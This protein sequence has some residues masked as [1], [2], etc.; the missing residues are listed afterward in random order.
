MYGGAKTLPRYVKQLWS[1]TMEFKK[2][3]AITNHYRVREIEKIITAN[4][5]YLPITICFQITEKLHGA[6]FSILVD[7]NTYTMAKRTSELTEDENFYGYQEVMTGY[8]GLINRLVDISK[9]LDKPVQLYGELFGGNI[10]KGVWYG[11]DKKFRWYA[12][13]LD[14]K[15]IST[16]QADLMLADFLSIKVP[17]VGFVH[18][19]LG[20]DLATFI[21]SIPF[22][23]QS[24]LSPEDYKE[25]NI[26]EGVVALPYEIVPVYGNEY[27]AI[28][29]KNEEFKDK[30]QGKRREKVKKE[31]P[32]D[33][34]NLIE[35]F[36]SYINPIRTKDLM[37]KLGEMR[38][39]RE[40]VTYAKAYFRDAMDDFI[41]D[42][43]DEFAQLEKPMQKEVTKAGS[44]AIYKELKRYDS[45]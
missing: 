41:L 35:E 1:N 37:S 38:D 13:K 39:L 44:G 31:L 25:D 7:G 32:E 11:A 27:L 12:M 4:I 40:L 20:D 10:Q 24:K 26:C 23:F 28:K 14:G 8:S 17:V 3:N 15:F 42:H 33:V 45:R 34:E 29:K 16:K 43:K 22:R 18:Y 6:N 21:D 19:T 2:Y 36:L 9:L 5:S 30:S